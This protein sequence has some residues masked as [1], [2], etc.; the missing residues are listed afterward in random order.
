MYREIN[1]E[2]P[3]GTSTVQQELMLT[4]LAHQEPPNWSLCGVITLVRVRRYGPIFHDSVSLK[5]RYSNEAA[6][7]TVHS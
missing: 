1:D 2:I 7:F 4:K 3:S 6:S 5:C